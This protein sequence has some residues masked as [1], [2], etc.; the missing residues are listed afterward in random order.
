[1]AD[2][3]Y[4]DLAAQGADRV[5]RK[6]AAQNQSRNGGVEVLQ[7]DSQR[8]EG[9]KEAAGQLNTCARDDKSVNAS[10]ARG[11]SFESYHTDQTEDRLQIG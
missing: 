8:K 1:M 4:D 5:A 9:S 10:R 11:R 7:C 6:I 3:L 2:S